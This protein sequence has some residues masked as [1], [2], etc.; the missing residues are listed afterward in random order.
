MF[1]GYPLRKYD[2]K[3]W[4]FIFLSS[5]IILQIIVILFLTGIIPFFQSSMTETTVEMIAN[6]GVVYGSI[7]S[8][9]LSLYVIYKRKIPLFN[10]KKLSSEDSFI[11]RGL[12][13]EDWKF[14]VKYIPISYILYTLGSVVVESIFGMSEAANQLA[15]ES[16]FDQLPAWQLFLMIVIVA[17][18]TEEILFRGLILFPGNKLDTTWL[19]V[20]FSSILFGL[21]HIFTDVDVYT[22]Y[23]YVGMGL[24]FTIAAKKTQSIEAAIIYHMLNNLMGFFA[25]LFLNQ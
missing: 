12:S 13:K 18:I 19:R 17:P 2:W 4:L 1:G 21:I 7:L 22:F 9:P 20:F 6:Y 23:T 24:I 16:L 3:D 15:V 5:A 25:I 8:L 14:L 10:R 11:I